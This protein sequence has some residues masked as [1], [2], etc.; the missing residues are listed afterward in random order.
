MAEENTGSNCFGK[1]NS[2]NG[3]HSGSGIMGAA[4]FMAFI[5]AAVYYIC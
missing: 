4:Y 5:G 2:K 3:G 1:R